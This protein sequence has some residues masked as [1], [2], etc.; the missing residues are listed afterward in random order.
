[1]YKSAFLNSIN[2]FMLSRHY[3]KR[4]FLTYITSIRARALS[5]EA[6]KN[7][8]AVAEINKNLYVTH[9]PLSQKLLSS[10]C[11]DKIND[12]NKGKP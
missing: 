3:S 2:R 6:L 12:G 5:E 11:V 9:T 10:S 8:S 1:M 4:T 7:F